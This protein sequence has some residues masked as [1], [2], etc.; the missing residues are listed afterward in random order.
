MVQCATL[1]IEKIMITKI[2][3]D[4]YRG[5]SVPAEL[6]A[7]VA[8]NPAKR[9]GSIVFGGAISG[10][11]GLAG[12]IACKLA[13][14]SFT[15]GV[16]NFFEALPP[17]TLGSDE[18]VSESLTVQVLESAFRSSNDAVY[19]FGHSMAAGGKM[20][21]SLVGLVV[22]ENVAAA[23]R[24]GSSVVYL[25][26][27]GETFAFFEKKAPAQLHA[28]IPQPLVGQNAMVQVELASI[29]VQSGDTLVVLAEELDLAQERVL[30]DF[31]NDYDFTEKL[32][33]HDICSLV[34]PEYREAHFALAVKL[35]VDAIYLSEVVT[36]DF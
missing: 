31:L 25:V 11:E 23:A 1:C 5:S 16:M 28:A 20:G 12:Q 36:A 27:A 34:F 19:S 35:G 33:A 7:Y 4:I 14:E 21:A 22:H 13:L 30:A 15:D 32:A 9:P 18:F 8:L 29:P 10:R 24:V 6:S 26:R 17:Q 3:S 2:D